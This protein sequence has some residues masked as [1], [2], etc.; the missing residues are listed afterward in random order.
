MAS[1]DLGTTELECYGKSE[2]SARPHRLWIGRIISSLASK[3]LDRE[4]LFM[5]EHM[6][7]RSYRVVKNDEEQ[8][9]IW[10][11]EK[12]LPNGWI[13]TGKRG[14]RPECLA[15]IAEVWTD[16]RPLSLRR[17]SVH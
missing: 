7:L 2:L 14:S 9:S 11:E 6:N 13:D 16:M 3:Y 15:Y 5:D 17:T 1:G 10:L 8:Y 4:V 12:D